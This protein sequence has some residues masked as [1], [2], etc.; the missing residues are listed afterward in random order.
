MYNYIIGT[1]PETNSEFTP[2]YKRLEDENAIGE[3]Y[4]QWRAVS[5]REGID[6]HF[7]NIGIVNLVFIYTGNKG[8]N[9]WFKNYGKPLGFL[10]PFPTNSSSRDTSPRDHRLRK[11]REEGGTWRD[12]APG[13]VSIWAI[14]N[15]LSRGHPKWWFSMGIPPKMA[16]NQVKDL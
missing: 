10:P 15:D 6:I 3:A 12:W 2:E 4:F 1:L 5:F 14:Y 8:S 7:F 11:S 16:L 9:S 13:L